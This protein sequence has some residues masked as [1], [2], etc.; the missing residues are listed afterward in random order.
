MMHQES[1]RETV[2]E[3]LE[4]TLKNWDKIK[5][6]VKQS[7]KWQDTPLSEIKDERDIAKYIIL[8]MSPYL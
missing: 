2:K 7:G 6:P 1:G 8:I 4:R 5:I 3:K